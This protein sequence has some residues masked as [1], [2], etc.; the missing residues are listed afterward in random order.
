MRLVGVLVPL[1]ANFRAASAVAVS[2]STEGIEVTIQRLA[3]PGASAL[4]AHEPMAPCS[5]RAGRA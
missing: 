1:C 3:A 4:P 2:S 5:R